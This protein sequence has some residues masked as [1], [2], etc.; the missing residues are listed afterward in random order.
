MHIIST[1]VHKEVLL[2]LSTFKKKTFYFKYYVCFN[3]AF[4]CFSRW[5][6]L[7]ELSF[8]CSNILR[9]IPLPF[10][11]SSSTGDRSPHLWALRILTGVT[12][13]LAWLR[14][15]VGSLASYHT[16]SSARH[17][18]DLILLFLE[19][20]EASLGGSISEYI[21]QNCI[22]C[23]WCTGSEITYQSW[24]T[25]RGN[26]IMLSPQVSFTHSSE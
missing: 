8:L 1:V 15:H 13:L 19:I 9:I 25:A 7:I 3:F 16:L 21:I 18:A 12:N 4:L 10:L 11:I 17:P 14:R 26:F 2:R 5:K 23:R 22:W 24:I 20:T 6:H